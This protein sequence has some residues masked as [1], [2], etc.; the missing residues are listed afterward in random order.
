M[1]VGNVLLLGVPERPNL[2][3]LYP[4]ARQACEGGVLVLRARLAQVNQ[5]LGDDVRRPAGH[6]DG[7]A[8]AHALHQAADDLGQLLGAQPVHYTDIIR[9]GDATSSSPS[10]CFL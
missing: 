1:L 6:A 5:Q 3:A 2:V 7:G 10:G 8:D 4:L 9:L